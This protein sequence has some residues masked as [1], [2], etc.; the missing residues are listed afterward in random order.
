MAMDNIPRLEE[1]S[2]EELLEGFT[3][4]FHA[5]GKILQCPI[6]LSLLS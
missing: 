6:C 4:K 5:F 3:E 2:M 1:L